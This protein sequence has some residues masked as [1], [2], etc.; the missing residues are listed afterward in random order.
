MHADGH[1]SGHQLLQQDVTAT[2]M[3]TLIQNDLKNIPQSLTTE[4]NEQALHI[5]MCRYE[6]GNLMKTMMSVL[7]TKYIAMSHVW[8]SKVE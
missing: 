6:C 5:T 7:N 1:R 2:T 4:S 8:G 3:A